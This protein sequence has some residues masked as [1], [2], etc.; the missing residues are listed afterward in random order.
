MVAP[1]YRKV[2]IG[3]KLEDAKRT[4]GAGIIHARLSRPEDC[5]NFLFELYFGNLPQEVIHASLAPFLPL[6]IPPLTPFVGRHLF[7]RRQLAVQE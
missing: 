5:P 6:F 1:P 2:H 7:D 4:Q 3:G